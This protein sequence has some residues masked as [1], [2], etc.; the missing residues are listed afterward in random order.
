M[1]SNLNF[2]YLWMDRYW[3]K[4]LRGSYDVHFDRCKYYLWINWVITKEV[5]R[6]H[7]S[8]RNLSATVTRVPQC[9]CP[10]AASR[11]DCTAIGIV[12]DT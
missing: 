7:P 9:T 3:T 2:D 10:V 11:K 6:E 12:E 8:Y 5:N 4:N 1:D